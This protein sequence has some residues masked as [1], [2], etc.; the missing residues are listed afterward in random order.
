M[1][2][3]CSILLIRESRLESFKDDLICPLIIKLSGLE[4]TSENPPEEEIQYR[5]DSRKEA[6]YIENQKKRPGNHELSLNFI[7]ASD[8]LHGQ[9]PKCRKSEN[10]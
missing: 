8:H 10:R 6:N 5:A 7:S 4:D 1:S 2:N 3:I 9:G